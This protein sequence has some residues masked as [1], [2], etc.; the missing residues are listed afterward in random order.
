M[1][2]RHF[3]NFLLNILLG[4]SLLHSEIVQPQTT[5]EEEVKILT[6]CG[7]KTHAPL[8]EALP[9][10]IQGISD[11]TFDKDF[12]KKIAEAEAKKFTGEYVDHWE[13][14]GLKIKAYFKEGKVDGHVHGWF[15][16]GAEAF[17]AFFYE[18]QKVGIHIAFYPKGAPRR[19]FMGLA[20]IVCYNFEGRLDGEQVSSYYDANLK[21]LL[22]YKNGILHGKKSLCWNNPECDKEEIYEDGKLISERTWQKKS[23]SGK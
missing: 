1:Q 22:R 11:Q 6:A 2:S 13:N 12:M 16:D 20:R 7:E 8:S 19:H 14:G 17:K 15:S 21:V 3:K 18:N 10:L 5:P 23:R 9:E 4:G